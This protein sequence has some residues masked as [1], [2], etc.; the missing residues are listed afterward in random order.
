MN[1]ELLDIAGGNQRMA[2]FLQEALT[3]MAEGK[4]DLLS[5]MANAVLHDKA[6]LREL[7]SSEIYGTE[8]GSAFD[9]SWEE[10]QS[11][12]QDEREAREAAVT[13]TIDPP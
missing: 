1:D 10:I 12:S 11:L 5:E 3:H 7:A 4:N 9:R 2:R 8:L 13:A 6:S